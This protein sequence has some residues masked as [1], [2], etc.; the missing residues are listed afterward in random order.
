MR[1]IAF[2]STQFYPIMP[3]K[4]LMEIFSIRKEGKEPIAHQ[5][6]QYTMVMYA[7]E[8][9]SDD[10]IQGKKI[11]SGMIKDYLLAAAT[12]VSRFNIIRRDARKEL[13]CKE[14]CEAINKVVAEV[15]RFEDVLDRCEAYTA[16]MHNAL[17]TIIGGMHIDFLEVAILNWFFDRLPKRN[18][19]KQMAPRKIQRRHNTIREKSERRSKSLCPKR[20]YIL[21]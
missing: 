20:H 12:L 19:T 18:Q 8:L 21:W 2:A 7:F 3:R 4:T 11:K 16:R 15:K 14:L 1:D 6:I 17:A 9:V 5:K 10:T 13:N